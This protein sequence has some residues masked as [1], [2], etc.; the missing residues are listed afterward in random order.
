MRPLAHLL[1]HVLMI[2]APL[3][4]LTVLAAIVM[5]VRLQQGPISLKMMAGPIERG[6]TAELHGITAKVDDAVLQRTDAGDY[7]FRLV[8]LRLIER[9]G[10][11]V[12]SAPIA[13]VGLDYS[14]LVKLQLL[15][16][17]VDF[18]EPRVAVTYSEAEGFSLSFSEPW[19]TR[20]S[21][22]DPGSG[23]REEVLQPGPSSSSGPPTT[24]FTTG[25]RNLDVARMISEYTARARR[26]EDATASLSQI[27]LR[28]ATVDVD[29]SG[30]RSRWK[31]PELS[32]DLNHG[33]RRS[34][35]SALARI[36]SD[37]GPWALSLLTEDSDRT[38]RL[39][40][41]ASVRDLVPS[42]IGRAMPELALLRALDLPV[43]GNAS[44]EFRSSGEVHSAGIA[45]E[46]GRGI[47]DLGP[48]VTAP[49]LIDAGLLNLSYDAELAQFKVSPST[50]K[51]GDSLVTLI[52]NLTSEAKSDRP[53]GWTFDLRST[54]GTLGGEEFQIPAISLDSFVVSGRIEPGSNRIEM[55]NISA[56]AGGAE[57]VLAG[58][59]IYGD[60][61]SAGLRLDGRFG[62]GTANVAK[63]LWPRMIAPRA[64]DWIGGHVQAGLIKQGRLSFATGGYAGPDAVL[65]KGIVR[66]SSSLEVTA[67]AVEFVPFKDGPSIRAPQV[68]VQGKNQDVNVS[69]PA[70]V[71]LTENNNGVNL[72]NGLF[73]V[74]GIDD[75]LPVADVTFSADSALEPALGALR[76]LR[77]A[78]A[79]KIDIPS[80]TIQGKFNGDFKIKMPLSTEVEP[81][82]VAI[83]GKA[84][85]TELKSKKKIGAI[86]V[87]SGSVDVDM[88]ETQTAAR[89][90]LILNGVLAKLDWSRQIGPEGA[91]PP[92]LNITANLDNSDRKQL[93][94]DVNDYVQGDVPVRVTFESDEQGQPVTR[95]Q[96]DLTSADVMIDELAWKK[97]RGSASQLQFDVVNGK[98][99]KTELQNFR[100]TGEQIAAEGWIGMSADNKVQEF[101]FPSFSLN[102]VSRMQL[103]G[104]RG[105]RD[106]WNVKAR[107]STFDGKDFFRSLFSV[108]SNSQNSSSKKKG[109]I[110]LTASI[111]NVL[112]HSGV[113]LRGFSMRL[114]QRGGQL[115]ALDARGTLD[116]GRPLA[117]VLQTPQGGRRKV[118]ADTTDGGQALRMIGFYDNM[119]GGRVR[120]EV[121]LD[122]RGAAQQ[123]GILW[124]DNFKVLGDPIVSEVFSG[125][126]GGGPAIGAATP[127]QRR[128]VREVFEFD[129]MK[130]P[131]SVGHGQ[132]AIE[133]SYLRGPILGATL[134]GKVDYG[135]QRVN[136]GGTYVPLQGLNNMLG[137]IPVL[138][139]IISGPR[140][141]GIFGITFA[142]QGPMGNPQVIV[143]PLSLV[144]PG[145][146]REIFQMTN[147]STAV[148]PR[149][150][151]PANSA[152]KR[153]RAS[154][155]SGSYEAPQAVD[156][157]SSDTVVPTERN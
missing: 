89:G 73:T 107:G 15:P 23:R 151:L 141:E 101:N 137:G 103:E 69:M 84:K 36:D 86:S 41:K 94:I 81:E 14:Q 132:F 143:N 39:K 114:S 139:Q 108:R 76:Q 16:R 147:P 6:I 100:I 25:L 18:I 115:T 45:I 85:I 124:I 67:E 121:D 138:G 66:E 148:Q 22:S 72:K 31:V 87:Q 29:Y 97:G 4:L 10:S 129:R 9:D 78:G 34:V 43:A 64:R 1:G 135:A 65:V 128:V 104:K 127:G 110:D 61:P 13:A 157:W 77:F 134:R 153:A 96:A 20:L 142:I 120:L 152:D 54:N 28:N 8:N 106:I 105:A 118:F 75:P 130:L 145:I 125:V 24:T 140:G 38:G 7:E 109:G 144:A 82:T 112:G 56:Q 80:D 33:R 74:K 51:W 2:I 98:T 133:E 92:P 119:Q 122:G 146:F 62:A 55:T 60:G 149:G 53:P 19:S 30:S 83:L 59:V 90:E 26:R 68:L 95:V 111:D 37:R 3:V 40:L 42:A 11:I 35:I 117:A 21:P 32:I 49:M 52:G 63:V 44:I 58:D 17:R 79:D 131:F 156:G 47:I 12:A 136:L 123:S 48:S 126:E 116:G 57:I 113:A 150:Q 154:S 5:Y 102:L 70:A 46:L 155:S 91:T 27:G 93:G 88:G 50:V 99:H 71:L